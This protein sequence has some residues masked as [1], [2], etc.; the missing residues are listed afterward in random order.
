MLWFL[1]SMLWGLGKL[2]EA[3]RHG[4]SQTE[5]EESRWTFGQTLSILLLASPLFN[6]LTILASSPK[7][8]PTAT[9]VPRPADLADADTCTCDSQWKELV[10][11]VQPGSR[12]QLSD[13]SKASM[14]HLMHHRGYFKTAS[15][16]EP[17]VIMIF[18]VISATSPLIYYENSRFILD[19]GMS[20]G[21]FRDFATWIAS[22]FVFALFPGTVFT[23]LYGIQLDAWLWFD[24]RR[25]VKRVFFFALSSFIYGILI[26]G[27]QI[28]QLLSRPE[29]F[30]DFAREACIAGFSV[31]IG[32][33]L[34]YILSFLGIFFRHSFN[35]FHVFR[36]Q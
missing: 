11:R 25:R 26:F 31:T 12:R 32:I 3:R 4:F 20:W 21:S 23:I 13:D 1:I 2:V 18:T 6:L 8:S 29:S 7:G 17:T 24:S 5:A 15:W 28:V 34:A 36:R 16:L 27:I 10:S 33:Y 30:K 9:H 14:V 19:A 22:Y 35:C